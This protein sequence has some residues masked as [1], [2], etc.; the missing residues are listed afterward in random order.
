MEEIERSFGD[1]TR[2]NYLHVLRLVAGK[3]KI[4]PISEFDN[5][6]IT[7]VWRHDVD[8]SPQASLALAKI[9]NQEKIRA[10]YF[11]N[12]RSEFYNLMEPA[13][14]SIVQSI[15]DLGHEIGIHLDTGQ[16]DVSSVKNL[17]ESLVCEKQVFESATGIKIKSFSFHNP[18]VKPETVNYS[19]VS[20][21]GLINAYN[22][23]LFDNYEYCSDSNGYWRKKSL[24]EFVRASYPK[25]YVLT[26][27]GWWQDTPMSPRE[28]VVRAVKGRAAATL[29]QYDDL[30]EKHG[31][32]NIGKSDLKEIK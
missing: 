18:T 14:I 9:E 30:L 12:L 25:I 11:F 28:R 10:S 27:P 13:V 31:R 19:K 17:E 16:V 15:R 2:A 20:Y 26:H 4:G 24:E 22:S 21:S 29:Q 5:D 6:E 8:F 23:N 32:K 3:Y 7:A 1:F